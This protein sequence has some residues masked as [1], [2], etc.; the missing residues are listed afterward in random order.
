VAAY[1]RVEV[2][3]R[4]WCGRAQVWGRAPTSLYVSRRERE[5]EERGKKLSRRERERLE[6]SE[7]GEKEGDGAFLQ[8]SEDEDGDADAS[9]AFLTDSAADDEEGV[10]ES[11][12]V[13]GEGLPGTWRRLYGEALPTWLVQR[14]EAC[15]FMQP[16]PVQAEAIDVVVRQKRDALVQAYTGS[17]KSLS[18]LIPLFAVLEEVRGMDKTKRR[19]AGVQAVVVAPTRELAM[20]LTKVARQLAAGCPDTALY[21]MS[22]S[23]DAKAK[24]QRIWLKADPPQVRPRLAVPSPTKNDPTVRPRALATPR[25]HGISR[26]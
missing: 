19:L 9:A 25:Q 15:G 12:G 2:P 22:V 11:P 10:S 23:S 16:T 26:G 14:L 7:Q 4:G 1:R 3:S 24:R 17:G 13:E 8:A 18:F 6:Q 20:Q 21:V 5:R